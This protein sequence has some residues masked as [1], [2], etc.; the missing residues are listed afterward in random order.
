MRHV[1][2]GLLVLVSCSYP[3]PPT[4]ADDGGLDDAFPQCD[5]CQLLSIRPAIARPHDTLTLEGTF[6]DQVIVQFPYGKEVLA[7]VSGYC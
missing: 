5:T 2:L 4:N 7:N 3:H 6:E 1:L